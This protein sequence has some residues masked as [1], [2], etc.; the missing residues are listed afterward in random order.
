MP[1][2]LKKRYAQ[3]LL[4]FPHAHNKSYLREQAKHPGKFQVTIFLHL[5][6]TNL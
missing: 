2:D 4:Q 5:K 6:K 1:A 3:R